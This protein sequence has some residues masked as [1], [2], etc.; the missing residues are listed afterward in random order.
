M[1][2]VLL[3]NNYDGDFDMKQ[4]GISFGIV[5]VLMLSACIVETQQESDVGV[6]SSANESS[7]E[8]GDQMSGG[9]SNNSSSTGVV[10]GGRESSSSL[11]YPGGIESSSSEFVCPILDIYEPN[12]MLNEH[13]VEVW[14][15]HGCHLGSKCETLIECVMMGKP[16]ERCDSTTSI[17]KNVYDAV[18]CYVTTECVPIPGCTKELNY[19]CAMDST[20][21]Y[22][23]TLPTYEIR[24]NPC[25][26]ENYGMMIV[27]KSNCTQVKCPMDESLEI[28]CFSL[29]GP[30]L[31]YDKWGC[32]ESFSCPEDKPFE[33]FDTTITL[34]EATEIVIKP[35]WLMV[36]FDSILSDSR[37]AK[38]MLC[39]WEGDAEILLTLSSNSGSGSF[40]LHTSP[41]FTK[42]TTYFDYSVE[43]IELRTIEQM[44]VIDNE[45]RSINMATIRVRNS[46]E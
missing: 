3:W 14:D 24:D 31:T 2:K 46:I 42:D 30:E 35:E 45:S 5:A 16:I 26:A 20:Y 43:L 15:E 8:V 13:S 33:S 4:L 40:T 19:V 9:S 6:L 32:I 25:M 38:D 37:C 22:I 29:S 44:D 41:M 28:D 12:C 39:N 36:R 27:D 18:G 23:D 1:E 11:D 10:T 34:V 17:S 21:L 7:F